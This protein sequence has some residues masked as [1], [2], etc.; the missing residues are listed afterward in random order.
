[1]CNE[2]IEDGDNSVLYKNRY[3]HETCFKRSMG[4]LVSGEAAEKRAKEK[5][6]KDAKKQKAKEP[7]AIKVKEAMSEEDYQKKKAFFD[8][9]RSVIGDLEAKHY[10]YASQMITNYGFTYDSMRQTLTYIINMLNRPINVENGNILGLIPYYHDEAE[11]FYR[12]IDE[13]IEANKDKD[14]NQMYKVN[15]VQIRKKEPRKKDVWEF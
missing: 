15:V 3:A 5:A 7:P 13:C 6:K 2:F 4:A 9:L 8:Y 11:D 10:A 14:V 1:M 12:S